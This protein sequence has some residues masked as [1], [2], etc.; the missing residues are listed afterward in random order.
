MKALPP[1]LRPGEK[2][3]LV[4]CAWTGER[5]PRRGAPSHEGVVSSNRGWHAVSQLRAEV[6]LLIQELAAVTTS[7][8]K[9]GVPSG[10]F[11]DPQGHHNTADQVEVLRTVHIRGEV[12][13]AVPAIKYMDCIKRVRNNR[14]VVRARDC[15]QGARNRC[16]FGAER[17]ERAVD[18]CYPGVQVQLRRG[19]RLKGQIFVDFG[20]V[21]GRA[22]GACGVL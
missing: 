3:L 5:I 10:C 9:A 17:L 22:N 14:E 7:E 13:T 19:Q 16:E 18:A 20:G 11:A 1:L 6:G 12:Y 15:F 2:R 8:H 21:F 4:G